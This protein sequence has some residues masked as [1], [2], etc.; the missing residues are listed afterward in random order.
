MNENV[1]KILLVMFFSAVLVGDSTARTSKIKRTPSGNGK[2]YTE[3]EAVSYE[4]SSIKKIAD[5]EAVKAL[6][7]AKLL[8]DKY[9][10]YTN[11]KSLYDSCEKKIVEKYNEA[12]EKKNYLEAVKYFD[13]LSAVG[14]GKIAS[15]SMQRDALDAASK[16]NVPGYT[17]TQ[18]AKN[19]L[20]ECIKGTVTV[21]VD[22]GI[23]F[24]HGVGYNDGV[25]GSGFFIT[26]NGYIVTNHHVIEDCVNP[27][28]QGFA[29]LYIRLAEDPDTKIPAKIIG[30][31]AS[32]DLALLKTEVDA[33][34]V[35][36]L[37]SSTDLDVGAR[38]YAIGSPLGLDRTL[39]S[40]IISAKDRELF[41]SGKVFQIDAA[42][43]SGNSGGPLIDSNGNVQAIVFAGVPYYQGLNFAIPVEY[44]WYDLPFLFNKGE[45]KHSWISCFGKT[46][47]RAGSGAV[48]EG[49]S[50]DYVMP[51][52]IGDKAGLKVGD[53]IVE[54]SGVPVTSLDDMMVFNLQHSVDTIV[55]IK[56]E[57]KDGIISSH[58]AYLETRP[59]NPGKDVYDHDSPSNVLV[60]FLGMDLVPGSTQNKKQYVIKRIIKGSTADEA[61]F[62]IDDPVQVIK[63][64]ID[65][66]L[67]AATVQIFAKKKKNGFVDIALGFTVPLDSPY[68][69]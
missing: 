49:L 39:T 58:L 43:N 11:A 61:G 6:W 60:P 33:P 23:K 28:Y 29:R 19:S 8:T 24:E 67:T 14:Y 55:F 27:E 54:I 48:N 5:K 40:G 65:K 15:L 9:P 32:V 7:Q 22:K 52:G 13:S 53:T 34:Y 45:R 20:A 37:G 69:F 41:S 57:D 46:K 4:I 26:R 35:F 16:K 50:V 59:K 56:T 63:V 42:V 21:F 38:V 51:G 10:S 17:K 62:S 44:L 68:Y 66:A 47:R 25:L 64:D 12:V 3:Q 30:Y 18:N 31:D 36:N 2:K 1:K